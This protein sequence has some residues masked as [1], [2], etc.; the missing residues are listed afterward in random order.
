MR[1]NIIEGV[2]RKDNHNTQQHLVK[3][4]NVKSHETT[5][6][7]RKKELRETTKQIKQTQNKTA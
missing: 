1:N 3:G 4:I 7:K 2:L 6:K 5:T